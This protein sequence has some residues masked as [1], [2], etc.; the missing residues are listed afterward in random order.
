[1]G[2]DDTRA[3]LIADGVTVDLYILGTR[4]E[5][6]DRFL[7]FLWD[8]PW[9]VEAWWLDALPVDPPPAASLV[10]N[11]KGWSLL[12]KVGLAEFVCNFFT[13]EEIELS[14]VSDSIPS[15]ADLDP[16]FQFMRELARAVQAEVRFCAENA[17]HD[18]SFVA[19]TR[20]DLIERE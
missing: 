8:S 15:R 12:V 6:W 17:P 20:G 14:L 11:D 2:W 13:K 7:R 5:H 10:G 4:L 9:D 19:T 18:P 3:V 1:M 16:I